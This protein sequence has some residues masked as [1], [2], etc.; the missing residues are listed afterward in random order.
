[1]DMTHS[2]TATFDLL[3][4]YNLTLN[5]TGKGTGNISSN[6]AGIDCGNSGT[7]CSA[8]FYENTVINLTATAAVDSAFNGWSGDDSG[9]DYPILITMNSNESIEA[10]FVENATDW[11][12][13][14]PIVVR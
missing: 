2:V 4:T 11:L 5:L 10:S 6:P 1:M 12:I 13:Y 3:P 9:T 7:H 14:L 8:V